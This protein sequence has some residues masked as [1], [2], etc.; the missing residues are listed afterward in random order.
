MEGLIVIL[1]AGI[2]VPDGLQAWLNC[3]LKDLD[4]FPE[5]RGILRLNRIL[6]LDVEAQDIAQ[7]DNASLKRVLRVRISLSSLTGLFFDLGKERLEIV[8]RI[9][10]R[11]VPPKQV[12]NIRIGDLE[13]LGAIGVFRRR[14]FVWWCFFVIRSQFR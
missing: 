1:L 4:L 3:L 13:N 2:P 10:T 12:K 8:K 6:K 9:G 7:P 11:L 14:F 5:V